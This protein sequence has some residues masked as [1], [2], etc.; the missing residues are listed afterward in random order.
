TAYGE[1]M[2]AQVLMNAGLAPRYEP[3][4]KANG[5]P[6][7]PDWVCDGNPALVC[8]AFTAGCAEDLDAHQT[9]LRDI[10]HRLKK[11]SHVAMIRIEIADAAPLDAGARKLLVGE[12]SSWLSTHPT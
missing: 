4:L 10:E 5:N 12:I 2:T 7:T 1:L 6:I 9:S 3:I 11:L 8:D